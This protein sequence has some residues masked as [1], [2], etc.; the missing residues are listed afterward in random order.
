[1]E[2]N[3]QVKIDQERKLDQKRRVDQE[4]NHSILWQLFSEAMDR[5]KIEPV[6]QENN[7][8]IVKAAIYYAVGY[9]E[10]IETVLDKFT[11]HGMQHSFN[12]LYIMGELLENIKINGD[13]TKVSISSFEAEILILSAF[14]HDI[15]MSI[16]DGADIKDER[17]Y[18]EYLQKSGN[19]K[20]DPEKKYIRAKHHERVELFTKDYLSKEGRLDLQNR[21]TST[22]TGTET[23][24]IGVCRSHN[25]GKEGLYEL[26]KTMGRD[27][28]FCAVILRMA[29]IFDL[30]NSRAPIDRMNSIEFDE[31]EEDL[32]SWYEW[33][34]NRDAGGVI[35]DNRDTLTLTGETEKPTVYRKL[36]EMVGAIERELRL[37][38]EILADASEKHRDIRLPQY[39]K[40]DVNGKGFELGEYSYTLEKKDMENLFM[41]ENLYMD[42]MVFV[43]ELLQN[44]IDATVYYRKA[45]LE[46]YRRTGGISIELGNIP[47]NPIEINIWNDDE[48]RTAFSIC[49]YG[50]G[51]NNKIIKDY[52]LKIG[53]SFYSSDLFEGAGVEFEAISRFGIGF[54]AT[55]MVTDKI[56]VVT[57]H[58]KDGEPMRQLILDEKE[59]DYIVRKG[60]AIDGEITGYDK[61]EITWSKMYMGEAEPDSHGTM[62]YFQIKEE[63]L[64]TE[65]ERFIQRLNKYLFKP[66]VPVHCTVFGQEI[67]YDDK[68]PMSPLAGEITVKLDKNGI[69]GVREEAYS[70]NEDILFESHSIAIKH[71]DEAGSIDGI[72]NVMTVYDT[73][74]RQKAYNFSY[75][76]DYEEKSIWVQMGAYQK[77]IEG[78]E[79]NTDYRD[80][81]FSDKVRIYYNG[82]NHLEETGDV[83]DRKSVAPGFVC[84]CIRLE[85]KYKPNVNVARSGAGYLD[86]HTMERVNYLYW[87]QI[88]DY[89]KEDSAKR[90][91]YFSLQQPDILTSLQDTI[92]CDSDLSRQITDLTPWDD[93]PIIQTE[94]G[95]YSV[96]EIQ[97]LLEKG[98]EELELWEDIQLNRT[99]NFRKLMVCYLLQ[100]SF[101]VVLRITESHEQVLIKKEKEGADDM[102]LPPLCMMKYE[103]MD[104]LKYG[105]YPL[106][107]AHAFSKWLAG[108]K[109][110]KETENSRALLL[111][112][113]QGEWRTA[114]PRRKKE[115]I[116][117]INRVWEKYKQAS[118]DHRDIITYGRN[119]EDVRK[120]LEV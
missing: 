97:N 30:D 70:E 21:N 81:G 115:Q 41:R 47:I 12:V 33:R 59:K 90:Y 17:G 23:A 14:F 46:K 79:L 62:I 98:V 54:L 44:A 113:L 40:N 77:E 8:L 31:T 45:T 26:K 53:K 1:M 52:F 120:W 76:L 16:L 110:E 83:S 114:E 89:V 68:E 6:D 104:V 64:D 72:L 101:Q 5:E 42:K 58:Y 13:N 7:R 18:T 51:M 107:S 93:L 116:D 29:D 111:R 75:A 103:G 92:Y 85:G 65:K 32:Y 28:R 43:R 106:N 3:E 117:R 36:K 102:G 49:D 25:M 60:E 94:K 80:K 50:T 74:F 48:N 10:T 109:K 119:S 38:D 73:G 11:A 67:I 87:K 63:T 71:Q 22:Q 105:N 56:T 96:R 57:K 55:Y 91:A 118:I 78:V 82:I 112:I 37:C 39:I 20:K 4:L 88:H 61:K 108:F 34:K 19:I 66:P 84:G 86:L 2:V 24:L 100:K 35:F 27:M 69:H 95:F 99:N 15:G 9:I